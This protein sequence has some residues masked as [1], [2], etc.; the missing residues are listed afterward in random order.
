MASR[1]AS[2][3]GTP[4]RRSTPALMWVKRRSWPLSTLSIW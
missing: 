4:C 3:T 2:A 1:I